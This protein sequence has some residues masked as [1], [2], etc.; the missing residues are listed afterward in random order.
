LS[1]FF[2]QGINLY[3]LADKTKEEVRAR[4]NEFLLERTTLF[5]L[6]KFSHQITRSLLAGQKEVTDLVVAWNKANF[7]SSVENEDYF[8]ESVI[9]F[10]RV[11]NILAGKRYKKFSPSLLQEKA[12]KELYRQ[13][14]RIKEK[15]VLSIKAENYP[16]TLTL[17]LSLKKPIDDFFDQVLVMTEKEEIRENRLGLLD[18]LSQS[19][20]KLADFS[21]FHFA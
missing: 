14:E 3:P 7:L 10:S 16:Q 17:L 21:H 13:F 2:H 9:S 19:F 8:K 1:H 20:L 5:F 11:F 15:L 6:E 12:E 18:L 4:L